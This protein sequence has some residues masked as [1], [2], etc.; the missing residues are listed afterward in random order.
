MHQ[1][2]DQPANAIIVL[3]TV[4]SEDQATS[5][6]ET[7]IETHLAACV[8][9][10]PA[11]R[12]IYRWKGKIWDDEEF[13]LVIKT[14]RAAFPAA[15]DTIKTLHSYELPEILALSIVDGDLGALEWLC[16][17]VRPQQTTASARAQDD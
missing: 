2:S 7:L 5:I 13:M 10:Q 8:N 9:I 1:P 16:Q 3:T 15:R 17:S 11:V 12:S 14:T 4:G 6:A